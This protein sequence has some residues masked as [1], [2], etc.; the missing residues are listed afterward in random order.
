[1]VERLAKTGTRAAAIPSG[2]DYGP[3][4]QCVLCPTCDAHYCTLD[5]KMDADT[6]ALRPALRTGNV[7]LATNTECLVVL[8]DSEGRRATGIRV[9][10]A[11][12]EHVVRADVVAICAGLPGSATLLRRSR[13]GHHPEGL[14]NAGGALG[15]YL[16]GHS[17][18]MIFP[19]VSL[20][21]VPAFYTKTF[22]INEFYDEAPGWP[23]PAG[24]IQVAGQMPFWEEAGRLM[25]P[26]ARLV[27]KH[28]L[29]CFYM[30]EALPTRETGFR[31]D[32]DRLGG[33]VEPVHNLATFNKLRDLAVA[34][35]R[36][37]GYPSLARKRPPYLW[38]E[39]GTARFGTDPGDS[40]LDPDCQVHGVRD[41]YVVDASTLP[42]AGAVNTALTIV[43]LA[44]RA[45]DHIA[46]RSTV[47]AGRGAVPAGALHAPH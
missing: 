29:M 6:A 16:G 13:T 34:A 32:G 37:A 36:R 25:R 27:G 1:M 30:T 35:F 9:R 22:A 3:G 47:Q 45:G 28:S 12:E 41:L 20:K 39:V 14:G 40:V 33:K 44:L 24:V 7:R 31:F 2:L 11:G 43:A 17:V 23:Y 8:T 18:G 21:T 4:G 46:R 5:A 15:R 10:H 38:H 42:S 19:F 26:I